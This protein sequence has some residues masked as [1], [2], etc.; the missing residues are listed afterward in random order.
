MSSREDEMVSA[1]KK[2]LYIWI[3]MVLSLAAA[4]IWISP[5]GSLKEIG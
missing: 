2:I 3:G 5:G 1:A 4:G